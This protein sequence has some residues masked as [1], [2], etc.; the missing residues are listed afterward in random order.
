MF[1]VAGHAPRSES[2][3]AKLLPANAVVTFQMHYTAI[4]SE[5]TDETRLGLYFAKQPPKSALITTAAGTTVTP[6]CC[7]GSPYTRR[8]VIASRA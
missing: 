8:T 6:S 3:T 5:E 7:S 4:G 1:S 2:F